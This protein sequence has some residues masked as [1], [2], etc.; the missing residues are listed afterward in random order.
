MTYE[1]QVCKTVLL[2][3][4]GQ[5]IFPVGTFLHGSCC[6][7]ALGIPAQ[8]RFL[9]QPR[10]HFLHPFTPKSLPWGCAGATSP[11]TRRAHLYNCRW[12]RRD[13]LVPEP[14]ARYIPCPQPRSS[15]SPEHPWRVPWPGRL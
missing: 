3:A 10:N 9:T 13:G 1:S 12:S 7:E 6:S 15:I 4:G 8:L 14:H 2:K 11:A 5:V